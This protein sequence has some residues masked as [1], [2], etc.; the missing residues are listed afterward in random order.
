[1]NPYTSMVEPRTAASG[2]YWRRLAAR[3]HPE[4]PPDLV[5][6]AVD[7]LAHGDVTITRYGVRVAL[8]GDLGDNR[9]ASGAGA[10]WPERDGGCLCWSKKK[11]GQCSHELAAFL[12]ATERG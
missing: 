10:Y 12:R 3:N 9:S 7:R 1:M 6:R 11:S 2:D 4:Y 5:D 8:R